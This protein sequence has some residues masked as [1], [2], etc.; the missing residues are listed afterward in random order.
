MMTEMFT[1][2]KIVIPENAGSKGDFCLVKGFVRSLSAYQ[3]GSL[4]IEPYIFLGLT[5]EIVVVEF[6]R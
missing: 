2:V 3:R 4:V 6:E 1:S 5:I